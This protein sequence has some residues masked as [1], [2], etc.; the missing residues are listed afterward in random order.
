M[1]LPMRMLA[2][3]VADTSITRTLALALRSIGGREL[4]ADYLGVTEAQLEDWLAGRRTPPT[5]I[6]VRALDIV[7]SGPFAKRAGRQRTD[8]RKK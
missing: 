6:Y 1:E 4:L 3:I 7:A 5:A 2:A 8:G